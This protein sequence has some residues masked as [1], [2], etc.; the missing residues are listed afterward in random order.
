MDG[1]TS[2]PSPSTPNQRHTHA[3]IHFLFSHSRSISLQ[4]CPDPRT[5]VNLFHR[6]WLIYVWWRDVSRFLY[7]VTKKQDILKERSHNRELPLQKYPHPFLENIF[8]NLQ[9]ITV[10]RISPSLV[11][12]CKSY[13]FYN[14]Y[15]FTVILIYL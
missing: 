1:Q 2:I 11:V 13:L 8:I 15:D 6:Y 7:A 14:L 12:E 5:A 10:S 4:L 9:I 3:F